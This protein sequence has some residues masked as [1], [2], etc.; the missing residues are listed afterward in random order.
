M[1]ASDYIE[2]PS[3]LL[4]LRGKKKKKEL[5]IFICDQFQYIIYFNIC[6]IFFYFPLEIRQGSDRNMPCGGKPLN[7]GYQKY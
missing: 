7:L 6:I 4:T 1:K 5:P 3:F 2:Q